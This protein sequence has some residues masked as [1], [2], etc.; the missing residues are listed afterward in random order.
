MSSSLSSQ[1]LVL[2]RSLRRCNVPAASRTNRADCLAT[3]SGFH[4]RCRSP[5]ELSGSA[6]HGALY[7]PARTLAVSCR[8]TLMVSVKRRAYVSLWILPSGLLSCVPL[9][10]PLAARLNSACV[11]KKV[12]RA[13]PYASSGADEGSACHA[14]ARRSSFLSAAGRV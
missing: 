12:A 3:Y 9:V 4:C 7:R 5:L 2:A 13:T 14:S 8:N 11:A 1:T 6:S 10:T